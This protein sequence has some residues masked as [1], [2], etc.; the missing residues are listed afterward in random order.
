MPLRTTSLPFLD[1]LMRHRLAFTCYTGVRLLS[2]PVHHLFALLG[3][4]DETQVGFDMLYWCKG[5]V[6]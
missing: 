4:V 2:V 6:V 3:P 1:L 5:F